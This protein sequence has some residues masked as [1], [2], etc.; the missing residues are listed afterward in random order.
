MYF[1]IPLPNSIKH[2]LEKVSPEDKIEILDKREIDNNV[3]IYHEKSGYK[4]WI[5]KSY[6]S[7]KMNDIYEFSSIR[8]IEWE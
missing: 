8:K 3:L 5:H 2:L 6:L 4:G 7:E 1:K